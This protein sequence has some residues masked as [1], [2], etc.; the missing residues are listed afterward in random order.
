VPTVDL[1][2]AVG[3]IGHALTGTQAGSPRSRVARAIV[4]WL[5]IAYGLGW[6]AG[7]LTGCGRFAAGCD[8]TTDW[9]VILAQAAVLAVLLLV[10]SVASIA[11]TAALVLLASA[12]VAALALSSSE[13]APDREARQSALGVVLLVAWLVGV[14]IALVRRARSPLTPTRPVS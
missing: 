7:E 4:G 5:P 10:P 13:Y 9:L 1:E 8:G 2:R 12:P 14:V 3:E 11:A 6:V